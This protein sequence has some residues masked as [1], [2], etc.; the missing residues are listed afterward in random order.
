MNLKL[1]KK[2]VFLPPPPH[3][4]ANAT[5]KSINLKTQITVHRLVV[6]SGLGFLIFIEKDPWL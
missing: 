5:L 3:I 1:I 4:L 6:D 2:S